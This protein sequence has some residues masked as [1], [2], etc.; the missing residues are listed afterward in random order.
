[1]S[2]Y[3]SLHYR[4]IYLIESYNVCRLWTVMCVALLICFTRIIKHIAYLILSITQCVIS[5]INSMC[6]IIRFSVVKRR[7]AQWHFQ[8]SEL[9]GNY[10]FWRKGIIVYL[11]FSPAII[12]VYQLTLQIYIYICVVIKQNE[13]EVVGDMLLVSEVLFPFNICKW[14]CLNQL[15][16]ASASLMIHKSNN[17]VTKIMILYGF[18]SVWF[19]ILLTYVWSLKLIWNQ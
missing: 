1:M 3:T 11:H 7:R 17:H 4:L 2:H 18:T 13:S 6:P 5:A 15:L 12:M 16:V 8:I 19:Q 14:Q 9:S 10:C